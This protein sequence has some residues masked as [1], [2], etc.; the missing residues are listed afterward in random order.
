MIFLTPLALI[1]LAALPLIWW[2]IRATPPQPRSQRFPS[3]LVLRGLHARRADTE[4]APLW[5]LLLRVGAALLLILGLAQPVHRPRATPGTSG[6]SRLILVLDDG[7]A[8]VPHW[9]E[10]LRALRALGDR[11]LRNGRQVVVLRSARGPDGGLPDSF[12]TRDAARFDA[13]ASRLRP[14]SWP[15]DRQALIAALHGLPAGA[16][17]VVVLSDSVASPQDEALRRALAAFGPVSDMRWTGCDVAT[18]GARTESAAALRV[19]VKAL[20]CPAARVYSVHARTENG[21][22]LALQTVALPAERTQAM[23]EFPLPA[24]LRNQTARLTLTDTSSPAPTGSGGIRLLD[25]GDRRRP[26]GVITRPGDETPLLGAGFFLARALGPIVELRR[27]AVDK[28]LASPLSVLIAPDGTLNQSS[29]RARVEDWVRQG[30]ELIRFAGPDL[31]PGQEDAQTP[32]APTTD[33]LLPVPLLGTMRQLGGPMSWGKPQKLAPF[34]ETS[35]FAGLKIPAE[36]TVSRQVLARPAA[37]LETH[38]WARLADGTPLV[39]AAPLGHGE[40]VLFHVTPGA[41]WSNLPLSGLFPEMLQRLVRRSTGLRDGG[42]ATTLAPVAMLDAEGALVPPPPGARP[43]DAMQIGHVVPSAEHP[44]GLYGPRSER[45]ALNLGDSLPDLAPE[46]LLGASV[47]PEGAAA[48]RPLGPLLIALGLLL[49][50]ADLALSLNRRGLFARAVAALLLLAPLPRTLHAQDTPNA[51]P[52]AALQ[53]RLAYVVTGHDDVDQAVREGMEGLSKYATDRTSAELGPPDG[54]HPGTDD[55]AFYPLIYWP[56][57]AD[58]QPDPRRTAALNT[59]MAHGGILMIDTLGAGTE[60]DPDSESGMRAALRRATEGLNVPPLT[61]LDDRQILAH[62]F[63]LL[64]DFPGRV[65]GQP[66]W[67]ARRGDV[68]LDDVSPI[69]IGSADWAHAWAIGPDGGTPY[70]V[71]PG[72]DEQRT[73]AYRFGVNV[74]IYSLTGN[75][76]ADQMKVPALLERM[77][78]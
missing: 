60:L 12:V 46:P 58:T 68:A 27:G 33:P 23:A 50:L 52:Q 3:L 71:I 24:V 26:V 41:D 31:A 21:G 9:P 17:E 34:P 8:A 30:G 75:Y 66:I 53:T 4:R 1:G 18:L 22:T 48:D 61:K 15:V 43:L 29:A 63:Y 69:I 37:D 38:V 25:E 47:A 35:P 16:S 45:R 11:A 56:V 54:V 19:T 74:V 65:A 13:F 6:G 40:V 20:P 67:V 64:H 42:T 72:G 2:L 49:L 78:R 39:T 7:W 32:E 77:G 5:L 36:V 76:K 70:A 73:L 57:T 44:P 28:L 51:V 14:E 55:L 59:F 10:R 62:T